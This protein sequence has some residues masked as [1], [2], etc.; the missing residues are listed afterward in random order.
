[1]KQINVRVPPSVG[2]GP[3]ISVRMTYLAR[4]S[5]EVTIQVQ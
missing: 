3:A 1:L 5:N 2:S 4:P